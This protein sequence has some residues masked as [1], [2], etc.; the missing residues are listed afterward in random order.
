MYA[1]KSKQIRQNILKTA[2][3]FNSH[4]CVLSL[5]YVPPTNSKLSWFTHLKVGYKRTALHCQLQPATQRLC[6]RT[7][8]LSQLA[9][10]T[11]MYSYIYICVNII[12]MYI[13][14]HSKYSWLISLLVSCLFLLGSLYQIFHNAASATTTTQPHSQSHNHNTTANNNAIGW[15]ATFAA[16]FVAQKLSVRLLLTTSLT[17]TLFLLHRFLL[18][19]PV[20]NK[21]ARKSFFGYWLLTDCLSCCCMLRADDC[22]ILIRTTHSRSWLLLVFLLLLLLCFLSFY[23]IMDLLLLLF[24]IFHYSSPSWWY[25]LYSY[26]TG[27][28]HLM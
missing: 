5:L 21:Q 11:T 24:S 6:T 13:V 26:S 18:D 8:W 4:I 28:D 22:W 9:Y 15:L 27:L 17:V 3:K 19:I 25:F 16:A 2:V 7:P 12:F 10:T 1:F 20:A 23:C 14:W